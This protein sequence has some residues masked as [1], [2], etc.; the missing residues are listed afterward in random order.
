MFAGQGTYRPATSP[1]EA[2][3]AEPY[4]MDTR[5]NVLGN[6][7]V[8]APCSADWNLM[9][10]NDRLRFCGECKLNVYNLSAMTA[11][12][13]LG[14]I[15]E[16]EGR[17]CGRFYRRPDG[18]I[19]TQDCPKGFRAIVRRRLVGV[20]CKISTVAI[21]LAGLIGGS[22][23]LA[24]DACNSGSQVAWLVKIRQ[25]FNPPS[26]VI[27]GEIYVPPAKSGPGVVL[28]DDLGQL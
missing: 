6:I 22:R 28:P 7:Q 4:P 17:L 16:T 19:L 10:G 8:A 20:G 9:T 3:T 18:T 14:L 2:R 23:L 15:R 5:L 26:P 24:S 13:I 1:T 12:Q 11:D 25:W 27:M 21:C